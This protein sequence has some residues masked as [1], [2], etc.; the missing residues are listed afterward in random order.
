VENSYD[1]DLKFTGLPEIFV[2]DGDHSLS[3]PRFKAPINATHVELWHQNTLQQ[4]PKLLRRI[5]LNS[6]FA[7][8]KY[9][10]PLIEANQ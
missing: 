4:A 1:G 6:F 8:R 9:F 3:E 10:Q 7:W 2:F 5:P